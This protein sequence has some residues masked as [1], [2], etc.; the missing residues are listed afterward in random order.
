MPVAEMVLPG[1]GSSDCKCETHLYW[2]AEP[3]LAAG[4]R[5]VLGE[6]VRFE[7]NRSKEPDGSGEIDEQP[8]E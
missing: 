1:F 2:F 7:G 3:P 6:E 5:Q 4:L 8:L